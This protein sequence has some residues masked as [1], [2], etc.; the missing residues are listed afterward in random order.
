MNFQHILAFVLSSTLWSLQPHSVTENLEKILIFVVAF[1]NLNILNS[2]VKYT[3]SHKV[4]LQ[5]SI[6]NDSCVRVYSCF[7]HSGVIP[8]PFRLLSMS[9]L[10]R[11]WKV[12][13]LAG[14]WR[15]I[16]KTIINLDFPWTLMPVKTSTVVNWSN[17]EPLLPCWI[18][19]T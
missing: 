17:W 9:N 3:N 2:K 15:I 1:P 10:Q 19:R 14:S 7:Y 5:K 13:P 12:V 16:K 4:M 18:H 8:H 6:S 11:L